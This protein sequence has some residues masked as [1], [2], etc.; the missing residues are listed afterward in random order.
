MI[1]VMWWMVMLILLIYADYIL[2]AIAFVC[3]L[4]SFFARYIIPA[5]PE[6]HMIPPNA[7]N[8]F[9]ALTTMTMLSV[10]KA[11]IYDG[12]ANP[13]KPTKIFKL[14]TPKRSKKK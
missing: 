1:L 12:V 3:V 2:V 7:L 14:T 5:S 8:K 4:A 9:S 6:I 10:F 13:K 11:G